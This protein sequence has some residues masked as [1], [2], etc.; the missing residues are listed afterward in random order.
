M[1]WQK[2]VFKMFFISYFLCKQLEGANEMFF[3]FLLLLFLVFVI[4]VIFCLFFIYFALY[5]H[6]IVC[7]VFL[8]SIQRFG[9]VVRFLSRK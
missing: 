6:S 1:S 9:E 3:F 2:N 4:T 5:F 8:L 7:F